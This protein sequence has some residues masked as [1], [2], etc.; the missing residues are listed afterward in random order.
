MRNLSNNNDDKMLAAVLAI[1]ALG[2]VLVLSFWGMIFYLL[3]LA[4]Q[5]LS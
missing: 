4:I 2:V 1:W 3:Y 5:A